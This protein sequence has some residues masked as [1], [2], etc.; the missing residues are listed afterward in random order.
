MATKYSKTTITETA[1]NWSASGAEPPPSMKS[2]GFLSGYKPPAA[3]FN[4]FWTKVSVLFSQ[5]LT[6]IDKIQNYL[7][8]K[9]FY[10]RYDV[11]EMTAVGNLVSYMQQGR[12]LD[13]SM[14]VYFTVGGNLFR[15]YGLSRGDEG[16]L[17]CKL[18]VI[19]FPKR[20]ITL[21]YSSGTFVKVDIPIADGSLPT[22]TIDATLHTAVYG[23]TANNIF[24]LEEM[25][26][27]NESNDVVIIYFDVGN[28][29]LRSITYN[30]EYGFYNSQNGMLT[31]DN[32][33]FFTIEDGLLTQKT[34]LYTNAIADGSITKD[35]LSAELKAELGLT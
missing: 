3:Y 9:C 30:A 34:K 19:T 1:P 10:I 4:W 8:N 16:E 31:F 26:L 5:L 25:I 20:G 18:G 12:T 6:V 13:E 32:G 11:G 29:S 27:D 14:I 24:D 23:G 15:T 35:K 28:G 22:S 21:K 2:Q 7:N 33:Y 17:N